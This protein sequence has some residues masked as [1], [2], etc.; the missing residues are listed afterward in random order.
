MFGLKVFCC[1]KKLFVMFCLIS[2]LIAMRIISDW[3]MLASKS[4]MEHL[5]LILH[6]NLATFNF[7]VL[8]LLLL[9]RLI[10][11]L[12]QEQ[13]KRFHMWPLSRFFWYFLTSGTK[14]VISSLT[15]KPFLWYYQRNAQSL[16]LFSVEIKSA[17]C[18]ILPYIVCSQECFVY[19][20]FL[21]YLHC[22]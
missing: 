10:F 2:K 16:N 3:K 7:F 12:N 15:A 9:L 13:N 19:V 11:M 17:T 6:C 22:N 18:R 21:F 8:L 4:L 5:F 1:W 14:Q 20:P